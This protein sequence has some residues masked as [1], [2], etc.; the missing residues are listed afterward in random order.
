MVSAWTRSEVWGKVQKKMCRGSR[1]ERQEG[2]RALDMSTQTSRPKAEM[3]TGIPGQLAA[4]WFV[5][6]KETPG[7]VA[8]LCWLSVWRKF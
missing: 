3:T 4:N 6:V 8:P 5:T 1:E 2:S 7:A